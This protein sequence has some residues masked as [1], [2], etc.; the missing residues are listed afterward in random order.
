[1]KPLAERFWP[2][3]QRTGDDECWPWIGKART[4]FGYGMI[5]L[6][7][8][9]EG[10][11]RAHRVAWTLTFGPIPDDLHVLHRCDNPPCCNPKHLFLGTNR[12]NVDDKVAK[13]RAGAPIGEENGK[14]KLTR[15]KVIEIRRLHA[16]EGLGYKRIAKRIGVHAD[17]IRA[18]LN[19][20]TWRNVA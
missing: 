5:G 19:G 17:T 12:D 6:G 15:E 20:R 1:M 11:D 2:K 4:S 7:S 3:V 14:S 18:V 13:G 10:I 9:S 8:R 16:V